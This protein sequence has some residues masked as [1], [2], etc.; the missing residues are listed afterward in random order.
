MFARDADT[1]VAATAPGVR[2]YADPAYG[3]ELRLRIAPDGAAPQA[4]LSLWDGSAAELAADAG[5][6]SV[7]FTAGDQFDIV[8]VDVHY[9]YDPP[10]ASP[11]GSIGLPEVATEAELA[12]C[13]APGCYLWDATAQRLQIRR[14]GSGTVSL[15]D[16]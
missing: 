6:R 12:A 4:A 13:A 16:P 9:P 14:H 1:L 5:G 2:S 8:T 7:T 3:R 10:V 15:G 11:P